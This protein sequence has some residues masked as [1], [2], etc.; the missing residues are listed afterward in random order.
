LLSVFLLTFLKMWKVSQRWVPW[1][2]PSSF[3]YLMA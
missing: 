2:S 1:K 3:S